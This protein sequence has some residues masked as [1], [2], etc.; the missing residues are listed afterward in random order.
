ME[1]LAG[2]A[3]GQESSGGRRW[4]CFHNS[5]P[6]GF[7]PSAANAQRVIECAS[8][9]AQLPAGR[10]LRPGTPCPGNFPISGVVMDD[11]FAFFA[12]RGEEMEAGAWMPRL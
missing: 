10:Q 12:D 6:M 1:A 5:W 3:A 11:A 7:R 9:L 8:D 2:D 4:F